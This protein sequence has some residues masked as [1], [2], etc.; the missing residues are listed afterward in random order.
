MANSAWQ[1]LELGTLKGGFFGRRK[2]RLDS[3]DFVA[4]KDGFNTVDIC[5]FKC[6][7]KLIAAMAYV[8]DL[9]EEVYST[10]SLK[11]QLGGVPIKEELRCNVC[12]VGWEYEEKKDEPKQSIKT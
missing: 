8:Y 1:S 3:A 11:T 5:H 10:F 2:K 9:P 12:P 6:A 4:I 7:G